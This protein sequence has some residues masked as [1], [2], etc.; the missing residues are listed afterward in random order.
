MLKIAPYVSNVSLGQSN[1]EKEKGS[2]RNLAPWLQTILQSYSHQNNMVLAQKQKYRSMEQD[3]KPRNKHTHL[4][5]IYDKGGKNIQWRKDSLFNKWCWENW[6]DT[7]KRM[8]LEHSLGF[9][10]G[11]V[12][13]SLPAN[14][15]DTGS[16]PG[17]GGSHMPQSSWAHAPQLLD[18]RSGAHKPQLL[19]PTLLEPMLRNVR[20]HHN[21]KPAHQDE[22]WPPLTTSGR[23]PCAAMRTQHSQK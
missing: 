10:G 15:G 20:G 11:A 3:R 16:I 23:G 14:A 9:P 2:W 22:E 18:L 8:K 21:E 4:R 6:T 7:C 17:P 13:W 12:V 5:S 1:P 19:K